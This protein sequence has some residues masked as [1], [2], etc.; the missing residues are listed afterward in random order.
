MLTIHRL[1]SLSVAFLCAVSS[2]TPA[3]AQR[4]DPSELVAAYVRE[5]QT[6]PPAQSKAFRDLVHILSNHGDYSPQDLETVSRDLEEVALTGTPARLR[7]EAASALGIPGSI[8]AVRPIKGTFPRLERV[9]RGSTDPVVRAVVILGMGRLSDQA[10]RR[11]AAAFL[12]WVAARNDRGFATDPE[13]AI[14]A[15][16]RLGE[17]GRA[18]LRRLHQGNA[19][20]RPEAKSLLDV[21]AK[22]DFHRP[23]K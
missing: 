20:S 6:V 11:E 19:V 21:L 8:H 1:S 4:R 23:T 16:S 7:G 12:E 14:Q 13:R 15:L 2:V 10:D 3:L 9:Y 22:Y 5:R 18:A 17:E